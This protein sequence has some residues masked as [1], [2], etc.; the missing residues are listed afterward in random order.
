[1]RKRPRA[2]DA[3]EQELLLF[4]EQMRDGTY[5]RSTIL[6]FYGTFRLQCIFRICRSQKILLPRPYFSIFDDLYCY[7]LPTGL[8]KKITNNAIQQQIILR[9]RQFFAHARSTDA[10]W[11]FHC[12]QNV[13]KRKIIK[14]CWQHAAILTN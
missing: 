8:K 12:C 10:W 2:A 14:K 3:P 4:V 5:I 1:M 6:L 13:N 7:S 9:L 11:V